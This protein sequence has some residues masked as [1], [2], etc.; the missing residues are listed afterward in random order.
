VTD[1][2]DGGVRLFAES[3]DVP[4]EFVIQFPDSSHSRR[5][6]RV[7]WRLGPEVGAE[8]TDAK[9]TGFGKRIASGNR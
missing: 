1:I 2:S 6:C 8:F 4:A 7:V 5:E 9:L 3:V